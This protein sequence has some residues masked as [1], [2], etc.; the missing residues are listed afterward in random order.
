VSTGV[1]RVL[2]VGNL[3]A[4][5]EVKG[6]RNGAA[7]CRFTV[8]VGSARRVGDKWEDT[9]EFIRCVSFGDIA[10]RAVALTKGQLVFVEGELQTRKYDKDGVTQFTVEV[11]AYR[12]IGLGKRQERKPTEPKLEDPSDGAGIGTDEIPF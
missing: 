5:I 12:L 11:K 9:T 10:E 1:N 2:L 6:G 3:T 7:Y 8:A 4:D